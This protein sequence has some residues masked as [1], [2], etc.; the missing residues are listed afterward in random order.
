MHIIKHFVTVTRHR[1]V[2]RKHCFKAGLIWQGLT[3]DLSK[4]SPSEFWSGARYYQGNRSPQARE[5]EVLG[6]SAAWLHHKGRNKHHFEYWTDFADGRKVYVKMPA[7]YFAEMIC[8]R[9]GASKIYM[10]D[11]YN[12]SLPLQYFENRTDKDSMNPQTCEDLHYFLTMLKEY[13]EKYMFKQ[14]KQFVK[15]NKKK[16]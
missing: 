5:R 3:H 11:K 8:D 14:L 10:K 2:V 16:R 12:D 1:R 6:Y 13:G 4:Y 7:K 15:E 9:I